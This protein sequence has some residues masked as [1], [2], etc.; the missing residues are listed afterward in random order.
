MR[1]QIARNNR[2]RMSA[3]E[4]EDLNGRLKTAQ[5]DNLSPRSIFIEAYTDL[6]AKLEKEKLAT[7]ENS[8]T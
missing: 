7:M 3:I 5:Q 1:I 6:N 4:L 8:N 2:L